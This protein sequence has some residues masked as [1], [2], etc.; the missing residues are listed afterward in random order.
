MLN[1]S[2]F[3]AVCNSKKLFSDICF[4]LGMYFLAF[5]CGLFHF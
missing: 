3:I 5:E 1:W 4:I 2:N